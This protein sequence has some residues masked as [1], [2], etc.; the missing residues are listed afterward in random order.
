VRLL[1]DAMSDTQSSSS[2]GGDSSSQ[3]S[4]TELLQA[5]TVKD[6]FNTQMYFV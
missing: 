6:T 5:V 1:G 4:E 2:G 3:V